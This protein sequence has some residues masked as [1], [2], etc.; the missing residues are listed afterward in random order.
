MTTIT[1]L[2]VRR[3][4]P[5]PMKLNVGV[6][7]KVG[8]PNYGSVGASC[9]LELELDATLLERDLEAFHI[10]IRGA[11]M[12]AHQAVHE[13]LARLHALPVESPSRTAD[14]VHVGLP[15]N[16]YSKANGCE[17]R[18]RIQ[19]DRSRTLKPATPN[20]VKAIVAIA[21]KQDTDLAGL[22]RHEYEVERPEALSIR[23]ASELIDMLKSS[24]EG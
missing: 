15:R 3:F 5:M 12:A 16:G 6:S 9:N 10:Q 20:Q 18:E 17:V 8:L 22:L 13:E 21:R 2:F 1:N 19:G 7:R 14:P 23:Q 24:G 4:T 11:Y